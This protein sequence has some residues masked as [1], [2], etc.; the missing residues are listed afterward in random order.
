MQKVLGE[1]VRD[2][3]G[4][5]EYEQCLNPI[6]LGALAYNSLLTLVSSFKILIAFLW[7]FFMI[8]K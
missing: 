4:F 6:L 5:E 7:I 1:K 3:M 2:F 8:S